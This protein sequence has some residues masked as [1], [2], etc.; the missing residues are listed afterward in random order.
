MLLRLYRCDGVHS[1]VRKCM[2]AEGDD[3]R[4]CGAVTFWGDTE[5]VAGSALEAAVTSSQAKGG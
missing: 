3:L 5:L 2:H 1:K 4:F